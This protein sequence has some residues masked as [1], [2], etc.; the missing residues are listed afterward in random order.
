MKPKT[1][2]LMVVAVTCGL[3]ASYMTSRL[4]AD[5]QETEEEV[6][7]LVTI[8]NVEDLFTWKEVAKGSEPKEAIV[9]LDDLKTRVLKRSLRADDHVTG[10][11]LLSDK[12][13]GIAAL[14]A[15]GYRAIGL[16]VNSESIAGGFASLPM[17]RVDIVWTVR[18]TNDKDSFSQVL[19]ENVLVL[20]ADQQT[21]RNEGNSA[22]M[23]NVVTVALKPEDAQKMV[24]AREVGSLSLTLRK[25]NDHVKSEN[26]RT[27]VEELM[28]GS[29][30]KR[31]TEEDVELQQPLVAPKV[32]IP[33]LTE[34]KPIEV[35]KEAPKGKLHKIRVIHGGEEKH[36]E[37]W[38]NEDGQA[39]RPEVTRSEIPP[40]PPQ[41]QP[42]AKD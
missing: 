17:S 39:V 25:F 38:L 36:I 32:N 40:R 5:R 33:E 18:R 16:R 41:A 3:G 7:F 21:V 6:K 19:L 10:N 1:L 28:T 37:Y 31:D 24:L 4:L 8:K 9:N 35:V 22:M 2:I 30:S 42:K 23:A 11:D 26:T 12:D 27:T 14:M 29:L 15:Q 34:T 13:G 20:A